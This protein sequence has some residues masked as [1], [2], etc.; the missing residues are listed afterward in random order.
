MDVDQQKIEEMFGN[1]EDIEEEKEEKA[2]L[3]DED[4]ISNFMEVDQ[5]LIPT[6]LYLLTPDF[7]FT[8]L[9]LDKTLEELTKRYYKINCSICHKITKRGTLCLVCG[10]YLCVAS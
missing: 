1:K 7:Y 6:N 9:P 4:I 8:L 2:D 3:E 5:S 10:K